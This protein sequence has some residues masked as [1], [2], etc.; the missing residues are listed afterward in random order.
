MIPKKNEPC[1]PLTQTSAQ[2]FKLY[3]V[4]RERKQ[5]S[6]AVLTFNLRLHVKARSNIVKLHHHAAR[7]CMPTPINKAQQNKAR[8]HAAVRESAAAQRCSHIYGYI[9]L[10]AHTSNAT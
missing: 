8:G 1:T 3:P 4:A 2:P 5:T 9:A 10:S 7:P 6:I